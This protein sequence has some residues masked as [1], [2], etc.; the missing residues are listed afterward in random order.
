MWLYLSMT[1]VNII[2]LFIMLMVKCVY[3]VKVSKQH[4]TVIKNCQV[5]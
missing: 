2:L 5:L 3:A 4:K 1:M